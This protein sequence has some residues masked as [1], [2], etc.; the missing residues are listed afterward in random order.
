MQSAGEF[1]ELRVPSFESS[2]LSSSFFED[3]QML[4]ASAF[5]QHCMCILGS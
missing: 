4:V 1:E 3:L 5:A 2:G